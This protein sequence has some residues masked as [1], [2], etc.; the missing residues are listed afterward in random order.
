MTL[1]LLASL[2]TGATTKHRYTYETKVFTEKLGEE[3][4]KI[5]TFSNG[6][7]IN[8]QTFGIYEAKTSIE[9]RKCK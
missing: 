7:G 2:F 9:T 1:L 8:F 4:P 3:R 5:K 6:N